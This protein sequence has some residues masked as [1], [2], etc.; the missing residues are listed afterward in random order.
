LFAYVRFFNV[1]LGA[2]VANLIH[3]TEMVEC[4]VCLEC[5]ECEVCAENE[6][7]CEVCPDVVEKTCDVVADVDM[8]DQYEAMDVIETTD[9]VVNEKLDEIL[10]ILDSWNNKKT[11]EEKKDPET[12]EEA[13]KRIEELESQNK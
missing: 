13:L 1:D 2:K 10:M 3:K 6:E 5:E 8:T 11:V 7:T 12:L 4:P 9:P